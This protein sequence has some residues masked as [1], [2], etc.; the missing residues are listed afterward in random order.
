MSLRSCCFQPPLVYTVV[1][2]S[3][4]ASMLQLVKPPQSADCCAP[5]H[6]YL[7]ALHCLQ[8]PM[9]GLLLLRGVGGL[10]HRGTLHLLSPFLKCVCTSRPA[11][12]LDLTP[13][14]RNT[15]ERS[16]FGPRE[17]QACLS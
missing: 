10:H 15:A 1:G 8:S 2:S 14:L 13:G 3:L 11:S 5:S 4:H 9:C 17:P 12:D 7:R 6:W 16:P